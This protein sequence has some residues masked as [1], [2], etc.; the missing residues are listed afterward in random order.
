MHYVCSR[1]K[2]CK[3]VCVKPKKISCCL[4]GISNDPE[5]GI[6]CTVIAK[7]AIKV[8][9]GVDT[10]TETV[11]G[12]DIIAEASV[13]IGMAAASIIIGVA[14]GTE[15]EVETGAEA[16]V[17]TGA[18]VEMAVATEARAETDIV[19]AT[20]VAAETEAHTLIVMEEAAA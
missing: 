9:T 19:I 2:T 18:E 13:R 10:T 7:T 6:R 1:L 5:R 3:I 11:V 17:E 20:E 4:H 8:T 12:T 15:A 14:A 16:E